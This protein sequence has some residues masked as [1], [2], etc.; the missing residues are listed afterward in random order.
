MKSIPPNPLSA[1]SLKFEYFG[2]GPGSGGIAALRAEEND[3]N[4]II[5][6]DGDVSDEE[7]PNTIKMTFQKNI[8]WREV[9]EKLIENYAYAFFTDGDTSGEYA[10]PFKTISSDEK[11]LPILMISFVWAGPPLSSIVQQLY[12]VEDLLIQDLLDFFEPLKSLENMNNLI[13]SFGVLNEQDLLIEDVL[14][15]IPGKISR[16]N[17]KQGFL[18]A[19]RKKRY[20]TYIEAAQRAKGLEQFRSIIDLIVS[21]WKNQNNGR[22]WAFAMGKAT[23]SFAIKKYLEDYVLKNGKL[24]NGAH[25]IPGIN[26]TIN[27]DDYINLK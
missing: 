6:M 24:P 23:R 2:A 16:K 9:S 21:S 8:S 27:F 13:R 19:V 20:D 25:V 11:S 1:L 15:N 7:S 3:K 18:T 10:W 5:T 17:L 12:L 26:F 4:L 22:G 14:N